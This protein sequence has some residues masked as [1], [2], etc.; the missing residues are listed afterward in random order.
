MPDICAHLEPLKGT[1]RKPV[2]PGTQGCKECLEAG[3]EWVHLRLC[4]S[5][6]HV[7][8]CDSSPN[9]HA[10]KH[11]HHTKHPTIR[12]FEPD[13][14][15]AYCYEDESTIDDVPALSGEKPPRH[16]TAPHHPHA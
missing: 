2:K 7:G 11:F 1:D 5:C 13:E 9:R 3:D 6:G 4:M 15:W 12:S 14:D 10:T 16:Y 8:C